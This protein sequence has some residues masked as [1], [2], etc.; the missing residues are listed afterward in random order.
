M[1]QI[2]IKNQW[3]EVGWRMWNFT[4][5]NLTKEVVL[6]L[7]RPCVPLSL[8]R[9]LQWKDPEHGPGGSTDVAL[10]AMTGEGSGQE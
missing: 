6:W 10:V 9:H 3:E 4:R 2:I 5:Q 1:W 7:P 8:L